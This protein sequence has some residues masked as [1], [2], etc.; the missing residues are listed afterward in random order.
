MLCRNHV[1]ET[2][3][4]RSTL[5]GSEHHRYVL[6]TEYMTWSF[7]YLGFGSPKSQGTEATPHAPVLASGHAGKTSRVIDR[8][9]AYNL[10]HGHVTLGERLVAA[11][12]MSVTT[13]IAMTNGNSPGACAADCKRGKSHIGLYGLVSIEVTGPRQSPRAQGRKERQEKQERTYSCLMR[14]T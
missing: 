13:N 8:S 12:E 11:E 14:R 7:Q 3:T 9:T 4:S 2:K 10:I 1:V 5:H 6:R